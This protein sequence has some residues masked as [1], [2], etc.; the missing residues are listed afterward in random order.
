[1]V[2]GGGSS[3][4]VKRRRHALALALA[5]VVVLLLA[6]CGSPPKRSRCLPEVGMTTK[7]LAECGCRL[8]DSGN[9]GSAALARAESDPSV[10]TIIVVNYICPMGRDG[11][12]T[13]SVVNGVA[14]EVFY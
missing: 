13:V 12:A 11:L 4:R 3:M 9:L 10:Q 14:D 1:L 5:L 2:L 8:L 6:A 7:D